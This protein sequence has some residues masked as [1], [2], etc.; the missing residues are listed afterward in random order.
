MAD[1]QYGW[2]DRETAER[3]LRGEPLDAVD[4]AAGERAARLAETLD[5]LSVKPAPTGD[6]LPGEAAALAAFRKARAEREDL[7]LPGHGASSDAGLV[8]IGGRVRGRSSAVR[9]PRWA[10]PVRLGLAAALAVGMIGGVAVATGTGALPTPFDDD[11]GPAASVS[12]PAPPDPGRPRVP[13]SPAPDRRPGA[14]E[15]DDAPSGP[16]AGKPGPGHEGRAEDRDRTRRDRYGKWWEAV[17]SACRDVR[18][19]TDPDPGRR[20]T[21]EK[22]AGGWSRVERYCEGV[23]KGPGGFGNWDDKGPGRDGQHGDPGD[24]GDH[25]DDRGDGDQGR[26]HSGDHGEDSGDGDGRGDDGDDH[27]PPGDGAGGD[28]GW[29]R[30][31]VSSGPPDAAPDRPVTAPRPSPE[32]S[33]AT[34]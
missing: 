4:A 27:I 33:Y 24:R 8:R 6:E 17:V 10:R 34:L 13:S 14:T 25:D 11:P 26:D 1:E 16:P 28:G 5:A 30:D 3:L 18:R 20:R 23:L 22:L 2:L 32:P 9:R 12:A 21:L 15:R 31:L 7:A 29:D 19:G